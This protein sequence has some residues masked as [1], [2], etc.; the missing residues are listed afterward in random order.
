VEDLG[1]LEAEKAK[2]LESTVPKQEY[3][4]EVGRKGTALRELRAVEAG[5]QDYDGRKAQLEATAAAVAPRIAEAEAIN[6]RIED[7]K[8]ELQRGL[9]ALRDERARLQAFIGDAPLPPRPPPVP[10]APPAES[11][12]PAAAALPPA[13]PSSAA[14]AAAAQAGDSTPPRGQ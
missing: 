9:A 3:W 10:A 13:G 12:G 11:S 14:N 1:P 4:T 7:Q 6:G 5:L 2:L 8:R